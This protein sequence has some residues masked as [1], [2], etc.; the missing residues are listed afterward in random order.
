LVK[1][2]H[3]REMREAYKNK[4]QPKRLVEKNAVAVECFRW[5]RKGTPVGG[6]GEGGSG[7]VVGSCGQTPPRL[8][9]WGQVGAGGGNV[10][11][12]GTWGAG[13]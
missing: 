4:A 7:P 2:E 8:G 10:D 3:R 13:S 9:G 5:G 11:N 12:G 1:P 6:A